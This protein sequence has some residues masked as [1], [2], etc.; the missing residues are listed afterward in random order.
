MNIT[1]SQVL[2]GQT[3]SLTVPGYAPGDDRTVTGV[4]LAKKAFNGGE[5]TMI[6]MVQGKGFKVWHE[7][8]ADS[9]VTLVK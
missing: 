7:V 8:P 6:H 5:G 4:V 9:P 1:A 2:K 3:V